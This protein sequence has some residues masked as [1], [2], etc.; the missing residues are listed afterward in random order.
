MYIFVLNCGALL[1]F[2]PFGVFFY[3]RCHVSY[4]V[5]SCR[6]VSFC[7]ATRCFLMID[8]ILRCFVLFC[9]FLYCFPV[10]E[11][12]CRRAELRAELRAVGRYVR[13]LTNIDQIFAKNIKMTETCLFSKG[14]V[15]KKKRLRLWSA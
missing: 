2:E 7:T 12:A 1:Y 9:N 10:G 3:C 14:H 11:A 5:V 4:R 6:V 13:I 15:T 8:V